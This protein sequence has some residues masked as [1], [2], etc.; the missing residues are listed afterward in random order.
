MQMDEGGFIG[1]PVQ[2]ADESLVDYESG[3][4]VRWIEDQG[5]IEEIQ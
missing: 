4:A 5:W 3:T 1:W 2:L